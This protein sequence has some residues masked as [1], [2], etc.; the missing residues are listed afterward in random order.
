[1]KNATIV[2]L[3]HN[4]NLKASDNRPFFFTNEDT[5]GRTVNM[6]FNQAELVRNALRGLNIVVVNQTV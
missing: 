4:T 6:T 5:G 2:V 1:M 3:K